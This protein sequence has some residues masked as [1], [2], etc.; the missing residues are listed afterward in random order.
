MQQS[1]HHY[2]A[3]VSPVLSVKGRAFDTLANPTISDSAPSA[4]SLSRRVTNCPL[5]QCSKVLCAFNSQCRLEIRRA[6]QWPPPDQ[7]TSLWLANSSDYP[8]GPALHRALN[9]LCRPFGESSDTFSPPFASHWLRLFL[10]PFPFT[11]PRLPYIPSTHYGPPQR[12]AVCTLC[13]LE[14]PIAPW[15]I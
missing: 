5:Q 13:S 10:I 6:R 8:I 11:P 1:L 7:P 4:R 12:S 14:P 15:R 9:R 2:S 3:D